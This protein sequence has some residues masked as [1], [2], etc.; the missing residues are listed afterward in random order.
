MFGLSK[1]H[2]VPQWMNYN[3]NFSNEEGGNYFLK[4]AEI[5]TGSIQMAKKLSLNI[6]LWMIPK[7]FKVLFSVLLFPK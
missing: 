1:N 4:E 7:F 3:E 5:C 2:D 6:I